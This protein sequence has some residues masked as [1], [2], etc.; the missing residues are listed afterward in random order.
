MKTNSLLL[1]LLLTF[2]GCITKEVPAYS[3]YTLNVDNSFAKNGKKLEIKL[4][5]KEPK[6]LGSINSKYISYSTK[7]YVSENYALSKWSDSPSKMIQSQSIKY[8]S[9][10]NNY[11]LVNNS[12]INVRSDYQLLSEID[13][14]HQYFKDN[15]SFVEFT[16][17]VYLKN[18]KDTY[19]K[20]FTYTQ[21]CEEN[22]SLG[23]VKGLNF[24][25]NKFVQ[26]LDKWILDS[27]NQNN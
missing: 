24:V 18:K 20:T 8:L 26:D 11:A 13:T 15:K 10:T 5:I 25:V 1:I 2:S 9:S 27:I 3:T 14:F 12:Y 23:A 21:P 17:R 6:A 22:N 16:I 7:D 4:E 19:Y